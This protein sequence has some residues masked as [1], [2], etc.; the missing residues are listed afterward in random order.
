MTIICSVYI[1]H[2]T[3]DIHSIPAD[4]ILKR[5]KI[6]NLNCMGIFSCLIFGDYAFYRRCDRFIKANNVS[7]FVFTFI[8]IND[9]NDSTNGANL[10]II[11]VFVVTVRS[12]VVRDG[13]VH[14]VNWGNIEQTLAD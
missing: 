4:I 11:F 9:G 13:D 6:L 3:I 10:S 7:S 8:P 1:V 2:C 5:S 14:V 12:F